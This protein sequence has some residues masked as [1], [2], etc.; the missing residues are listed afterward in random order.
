MKLR[1]S[2]KIIKN[3]QEELIDRIDLIE[4][5]GGLRNR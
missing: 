5:E 2:L 1:P 4:M 3:R